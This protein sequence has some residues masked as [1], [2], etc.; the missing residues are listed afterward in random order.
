MGL[1]CIN[2]LSKGTRKRDVIEFL[3]LLGYLNFDNKDFRFYKDD[4][5]KYFE[6]VSA[7]IYEDGNG[8]SVGTRTTI[9]RS[10]GDSDYHN[11]TIKQLK[12]RFGGS[13]HSD[14][15]KERYLK[16]SGAVRTKAEAGCYEA[17]FNF[18]N[19]I[20]KP[21]MYLHNTESKFSI[22]LTPKLV[23]KLPFVASVHPIIF[24]NN[25]IIPYVVSC[26]EDYFK[27]TYIALL[28]YS[29]KKLSVLKN[30]R[31]MP[32]DLLSISNKEMSV[33]DAITKT[34]SFQ[35]IR[36][37]TIYFKEL[38]SNLDF[39]GVLR[40]PYRR[41]KKSLYENLDKIFEQRHLLIHR[42]I[43]IPDYFTEHL[44][45]D[46][47]DIEVAIKRIYLHIVAVYNWHTDY[48]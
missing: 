13:F 36:K 25:V 9:W 10:K 35:N 46:L 29:D 21:S 22:E 34:M 32:D 31:I 26:I 17:F 41:R 5:Y 39:A 23:K 19:N 48:P 20:Q 42:N 4:D 15:G 11:F 1:D 28:R 7:H 30:A 33:E 37:I 2:T 38:D 40:K 44:E 24:Q 3:E 6:G 47:D 18:K 16:Y 43:M 14:Y 8:L 27:S 12:K 45:K